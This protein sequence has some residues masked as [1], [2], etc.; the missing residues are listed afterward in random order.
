MNVFDMVDA[1]VRGAARDA[2]DA[3]AVE[4]HSG[5]TDEQWARRAYP[6]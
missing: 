5:L 3:A 6:A 1:Y 2:L 4:R